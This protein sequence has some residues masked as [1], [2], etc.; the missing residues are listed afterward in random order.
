[1]QAGL[2]NSGMFGRWLFR[3]WFGPAPASARV[4][5]LSTGGIML[6]PLSHR[7]AD[8]P[9]HMRVE[10]RPTPV[11]APRLVAFNRPLA[12]ELGFD[13][14]Y[15]DAEAVA[16]L[17]SGNALP[18]DLRPTAAAYAGHQFGNFVPQLGDGRALLLGEVR[19]R[20]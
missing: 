20:F 13:L 18:A 3:P 19:D 15:F 2:L 5:I 11:A 17:F 9:E 12:E 4:E 14:A 1:M 6:P 16:A 7:Y 8:L 10:M